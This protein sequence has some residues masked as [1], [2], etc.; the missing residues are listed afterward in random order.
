[1]VRQALH[2]TGGDFS[3]AAAGGTS[4]ELCSMNIRSYLVEGLPREG[5]NLI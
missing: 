2:S 3:S 4:A 1:M 5:G